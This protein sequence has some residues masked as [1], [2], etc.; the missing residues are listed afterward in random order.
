VE[1]RDALLPVSPAVLA[2]CNQAM[3]TRYRTNMRR[4]V[5]W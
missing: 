1:M 4:M 5:V 2:H 3:S